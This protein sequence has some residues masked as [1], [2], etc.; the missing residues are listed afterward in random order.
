MRTHVGL[1]VSDQ[2]VVERMRQKGTRELCTDLEWLVADMLHLP[3]A[4]QMFDVVVEKAV[5]EVLF[6]KNEDPWAPSELVCAGVFGMLEQI[7]R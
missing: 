1:V 3:F 2:V 4:A 5:M 7:H 6:V